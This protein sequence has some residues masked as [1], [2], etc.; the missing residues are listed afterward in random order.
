MKEAY[1]ISLDFGG[2][3]TLIPVNLEDFTVPKEEAKARL[4]VSLRANGKPEL[5]KVSSKLH[6]KIQDEGK[7]CACKYCGRPVSIFYLK[8]EG[9][10]PELE[11]RHPKIEDMGLCPQ[12]FK[13]E[14]KLA[15]IFLNRFDMKNIGLNRE[16]LKKVEARNKAEYISLMSEWTGEKDLSNRDE[17]S[18]NRL[19][20]IFISMEGIDIHPESLPSIF[21]TNLEKTRYREFSTGGKGGV[22]FAWGGDEIKL[23]KNS[24][25]PGSYIQLCWG[26][27]KYKPL[28]GHL[29][30]NVLFTPGSREVIKGSQTTFQGPFPE[31]A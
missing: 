3:P 29:E 10:E 2:D 13:E 5:G 1:V 17:A 15:G 24:K 23:T 27:D 22:G 21:V 25:L 20:K 16:V 7:T 12:T 8:K 6:Q 9:E 14:L 31:H 19:M 11:F 4:V 26:A 28:W 18:Y 30:H